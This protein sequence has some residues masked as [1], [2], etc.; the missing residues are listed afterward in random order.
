MD[1]LQLPKHAQRPL[2]PVPCLAH[3]DY[4]GGDLTTYPERSGWSR[5]TRAAWSAEFRQPSKKFIA[6]MQTW[7]YFGPLA[8]IF[9]LGNGKPPR[10]ADLTRGSHN[11]RVVDTSALPAMADKFIADNKLDQVLHT[12]DLEQP[13]SLAG[14][15]TFMLTTLRNQIQRNEFKHNSGS[16]DILGRINTLFSIEQEIRKPASGCECSIDQSREESL[17]TFIQNCQVTDPLP[18]DVQ[19]SIDILLHTLSSLIMSRFS[20]S[21]LFDLNPDTLMT[22]SPNINKILRATG[23]PLS[24]RSPILSAMVDDG[25]C[26]CVTAH[27][28]ERFDISAMIF[29]SRLKRPDDFDHGPCTKERCRIDKVDEKHYRRKHARECDGGSSCPDIV[30]DKSGMHTILRSNRFPII[31]ATIQ[32]GRSSIK[33]SDSHSRKGYV[34]ISHVWSDGLGNP[35]NNAVPNCQL[36]ALD[37]MVASLP[38]PSP[39][40][41]QSPFWLDTICCPVEEGNDQIAAIGLM[42]DTYEKASAVLVLDQSTLN[43]KMSDMNGDV[44]ILMRILRSRWTTRLWTLQEGALAQRLFFQFADGPYDVQQG[45]RRLQKHKQ[46]L[47]I[48][49]TILKEYLELRVFHIPGMTTEQKIAA[50]A[51]ALQF[52]STSVDTDEPICLSTLLGFDTR[53]MMAIPPNQRLQYFWGYFSGIPSDILF[54]DCPKMSDYPCR[55]APKSFLRSETGAPSQMGRL[56]VADSSAIQAKRTTKGLLLTAHVIPLYLSWTMPIGDMFFVFG[57]TDY[58]L[59]GDWYR[60]ETR[61]GNVESAKKYSQ[62]SEIC[63]HSEERLRLIPSTSHPLMLFIALSKEPNVAGGPGV[64]GLLLAGDRTQVGEMTAKPVCF[65]TA[66]KVEGQK[67]EQT[68]QQLEHFKRNNWTNMKEAKERLSATKGDTGNLYVALGTVPKMTEVYVG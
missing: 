44:E 38:M 10:I 57:M 19:D 25:W 64:N 59:G 17:F 29:I 21:D 33:L 4:D 1:H 40:G 41:S 42:R 32:K 68:L 34:A 66:S 13:Q 39:V 35:K 27:L 24:P 45:I 9:S 23:L 50:V 8:M 28:R 55:W 14:D 31:N 3:Q 20:D 43:E 47:T 51:R 54:L 67:D 58:N 61:L 2:R 30:V 26:P 5:R 12:V 37:R 11:E 36:E 56:D 6:L 63:A 62:P 60:V 65:I 18:Y 16:F 22:Y 7:R 52:R 46:D 48:I 15:L 53:A 49:P